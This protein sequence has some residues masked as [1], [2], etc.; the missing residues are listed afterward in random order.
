MNTSPLSKLLLT[1]SLAGSSTFALASPLT[2]FTDFSAGV[3][4]EWSISTT[5]NNN[6]PG[7]LGRLENGSA[8]LTLSASSNA[9][10]SLN[11]RLLG[12]QSVDGANCCTDTFRLVLNGTEVLNANFALQ[13]GAEQINLNSLAATIATPF[14]GAR[15]ISIASLN[16]VN[17]ANT[18]LFD[19]GVMQGFADESWGLDDVSVYENGSV[20]EPTA[21]LLMLSGLGLLAVRRDTRH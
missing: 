4:P 20:P 12:F 14:A 5:Y 19:Y 3:G 15:D 11:F 9:S 1:V 7:M 16:L 17:G 8:L 18:F 21:L 13:F 2:Y 10:G 6:D